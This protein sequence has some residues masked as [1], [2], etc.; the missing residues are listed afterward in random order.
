M[1]IEKSPE[2]AVLHDLFHGSTAVQKDSQHSLSQFYYAS[3]FL[4]LGR[5]SSVV[6]HRVLLRNR[7]NDQGWV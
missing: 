5:S 2:N 6:C 4:C 3:I 7:R 1:W